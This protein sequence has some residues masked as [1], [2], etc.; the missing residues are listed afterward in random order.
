MVFLVFLSSLTSAAAGGLPEA[1]LARLADPI[2]EG[3]SEAG[4]MAGTSS[5]GCRL[6]L[7]H[8][9]FA[10][11]EHPLVLSLDGTD[12]LEVAAPRV[13]QQGGEY[14]PLSLT[15]GSTVTGQGE[16]GVGR[17]TSTT[18]SWSS[19]AKASMPLVMST[20]IRLYEPTKRG[21][22]CSISLSQSFP[23]GAIVAVAPAPVVEAAVGF[24][25]FALTAE[26]VRNTQ[27]LTWA[28]LFSEGSVANA[29]G[30][31]GGGV[32]ERGPIVLF[33]D[34]AA[35]ATV[36]ALVVSP[37]NRFKKVATN[38]MPVISNATASHTKGWGYGIT[39]FVREY[40]A[41]LN[42]TVMVTVPPRQPHSDS[43]TGALGVH[44]ALEHWGELMMRAHNTHR[45]SD[46]DLQLL[47]LGYYT[48]NGAY[49]NMNKR[50]NTTVN[51]P[52]I[53]PE[54][55]LAAAAHYLDAANV[56]IGYLMLDD[57]WYDCDCTPKPTCKCERLFVNCVDG[58]NA[59]H[60]WFPS[61]LNATVARF[62]GSASLYQP[63]FCQGNVFNRTLG[64]PFTAPYEDGDQCEPL[65]YDSSYKVYSA[66]MD[67]YKGLISNFEIDFLSTNTHIPDFLESLTANEDWLR[68]MHD[69]AAERQ[70]GVQY[71][72]ALPSDLL[73]SLHFPWV[74]NARGSGDYAYSGDAIGQFGFNLL[75]SSMLMWPLGLA[76]FKDTTWTAPIQP[77]APH[78]FSWP[79]ADV[80]LD[81]LASVLSRGPVGISDGPGLTN[82]ALAKSVASAGGRLLQPSK[83][84]T[85]M[86]RTLTAG[87]ETSSAGF[88]GQTHTLV[89]NGSGGG[90]T[91]FHHALAVNTTKA[92]AASVHLSELWPRPVR[93]AG[94]RW[95]VWDTG[96]GFCG[97]LPQRTGGS[98]RLS[99][100]SAVAKGC[101]A[102]VTDS[103]TPP[104]A[105]DLSTGVA[106]GN[107]GLCDVGLGW[108]PS[109]RLVQLTPVDAHGFGLLGEV[110]TKLLP[111][112]EYRFAS[113]MSDAATLEVAVRGKPAEVVTIA[114][115][116]P[117]CSSL[118]ASGAVV[119]SVEWQN[120]TVGAS[121]AAVVRFQCAVSSW[122]ETT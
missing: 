99:F 95:I 39:G 58:W 5:G 31:L 91:T 118:V 73:T 77:N 105:F 64:V 27:R 104:M 88:L 14:L 42:L 112:S 22:G 85:A 19:S 81:V 121:G 122:A 72:M 76:P 107:Q 3:V 108:G 70:L 67:K 10:V 69:A 101:A 79:H 78:S 36:A 29:S 52:W 49:F 75:L 117:C 115:V 55:G 21:G 54:T 113:L 7:A 80:K 74:T 50:L 15:A 114:A 12:W 43:G 51:N 35:A 34:S 6:G 109:C 44:A 20:V 106:D 71:C 1:L 60:D 37:M 102:V 97:A 40:P 98:L 94:G 28:G 33:R 56:P 57:W 53:L 63:T 48:D 23:V 111:V 86:E 82:T 96:N 18:Q 92:S 4:S 2:Q 38:S 110:G 84:L 103:G 17:F 11:A 41:G 16:D 26:V 30:T 119:D 46:R 83:P 66:M 24:P 87:W 25:H 59:R 120:A 9:E 68:G 89:A 61:G 8:T 45:K 90:V 65:G 100:H 93:P 13:L 47:Q 62:N 32:I 116:V